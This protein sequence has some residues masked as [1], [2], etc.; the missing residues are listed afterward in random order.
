MTSVLCMRLSGTEMQSRCCCGGSVNE[1]FVAD[2]RRFARRRVSATTTA[3][4]GIQYALFES[5]CAGPRSK[6]LLAE[7][8][9]AVGVDTVEAFTHAAFHGGFGAADLLIVVAIEPLEHD[10]H[11]FGAAHRQVV[12]VCGCRP[13]RQQRRRARSDDDGFHHKCPPWQNAR[14]K[15]AVPLIFAAD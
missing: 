2:R 6:F 7:V 4:A 9:V 14:V 1:S 5:F 11:I 3:L 10:L 12:G 15:R 8:A 13:R